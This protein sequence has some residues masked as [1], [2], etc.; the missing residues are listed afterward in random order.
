MS[1]LSD[2][3]KQLR[4]ATL[5][6]VKAIHIAGEL[7]IKYL[8]PAHEKEDNLRVDV[9]KLKIKIK[10]ESPK[11]SVAEVEIR[12]EADPV[13]RE[14]LRAKHTT[15]RIETFITIAKKHAS[16]ANGF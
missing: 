16:I 5:D 2:L 7:A 1:N 8:G 15:E 4:E 6:P 3:E 11:M 13:F 10:D 12:V 9:A 14:Y